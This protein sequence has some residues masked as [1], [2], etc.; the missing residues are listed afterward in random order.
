MSQVWEGAGW[1]SHEG[2]GALLGAGEHARDLLEEPG[3]PSQ[4]RDGMRKFLEGFR[5]IARMLLAS[6]SGCQPGMASGCHCDTMDYIS[7]LLALGSV[8]KYAAHDSPGQ[9]RSSAI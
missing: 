7:S 2:A 3:Q 6:A 9:M 8:F 4:V 1:A 5:K